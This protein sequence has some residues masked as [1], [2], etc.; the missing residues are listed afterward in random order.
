MASGYK[1]KPAKASPKKPYKQGVHG[2]APTRA[3]QQRLNAKK[4]LAA[5]AKKKKV[6]FS[7]KF[8]AERKKQGAGGTFIWTKAEGG[9]GKK[10][11]TNWK[12]EVNKR[13]KLKGKVK[14]KI[15]R[16]KRKT[17]RSKK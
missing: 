5:A 7:S 14:R 4:R 13:G 9:T 1:K 6:T 2:T 10:Y 8:K 12:E 11:T 16:K 15:R 17:K 3:A